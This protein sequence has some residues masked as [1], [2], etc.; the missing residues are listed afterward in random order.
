MR[1]QDNN[2]SKQQ[3]EQEVNDIDETGTIATEGLTHDESVD[4]TTTS[5]TE[6]AREEA[7]V[8]SLLSDELLRIHGVMPG[9]KQEGT[10]RLLYEN[11]NGI[12]SMISGNDKL[13]KAKQLILELEADIVC[14][15]EH[16]LNLRNKHNKN[17]FS[18]MFRGGEAEIRSIAAHN[19][20]ESKEAGRTQEGGTA[21][22]LFGALIEY[23]NF[24]VSGKDESGLGRLVAM[25]FEGENGLRTRVV[26]GYN[27]C[28]NNKKESKTSYQQQRR[29]FIT[30][31]KDLTCPRTWFR[32]D[33]VEQLEKW[34]AEGDRLIVCLDVNEDIYKK[35]IGKALTN[36]SGLN[37]NEV[38]GDFTGEKLGATHFRGS[39][40]IDGIWA[41]KDI[42]VTGAC[43]MPVGFGVG[44]HRMF[45]VDFR[46]DSM[47]GTN[48][49]KV[50]RASSRRLNTKLPH[51]AEKYNS[52]LERNIISHKLN[53]RLVAADA[54]S[55]DNAIV[56]PK[57]DAIDK[58]AG[59][60]MLHAKKNCR[61]IKSGRIPF[62]PEAAVWIKRRQV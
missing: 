29:Y 9:S 35:S 18:Q 22:L 7:D 62:S 21:M 37:M 46:L 34:R 26:C 4:T 58:E 19:V 14:Y 45:I 2:E 15:N 11:L 48:P 28:Y 33:L 43:V 53:S 52:I 16:R 57:V 49:P 23:Y 6:A 24:E 36:P 38:V 3:K 27:A 40:P 41:T 8:L 5:N 1:Y 59:D 39:K 51:V 56:K 55:S 60:Y 25:V 44:D 12:L 42:G 31:E 54:S 32:T 20:H 50:V 17:G 10:V 47:I 30:K 61:K 13:E